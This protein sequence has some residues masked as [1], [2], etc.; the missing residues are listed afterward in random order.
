M[1]GVQTAQNINFDDGRNLNHSAV[2][3]DECD[4]SNMV[5]IKSYCDLGRLNGEITTS[6][7]A[8]Q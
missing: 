4:E 7:S 2:D 1:S 5:N 3:I 6:N 8:L